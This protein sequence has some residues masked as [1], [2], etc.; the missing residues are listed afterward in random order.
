MVETGEKR[1]GEEIKIHVS[2]TSGSFKHKKN[3]PCL[4][5]LIMPVKGGMERNG[6]EKKMGLNPNRS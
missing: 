6:R 2:G 3:L 5:D 1:A 4:Q